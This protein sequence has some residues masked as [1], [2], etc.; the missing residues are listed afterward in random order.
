MVLTAQHKHTRHPLHTTRKPFLQADSSPNFNPNIWKL[1]I[2]KPSPLATFISC[3]S[4]WRGTHAHAR[5]RELEMKT[6]SV[7]AA[8]DKHAGCQVNYVRPTGLW[9]TRLVL[10]WLFNT[11]TQTNRG[12]LFV[13]AC[14]QKPVVELR[15]TSGTLE[16]RN[17]AKRCEVHICL[18]TVPDRGRLPDLLSLLE[19]RNHNPTFHA[20]VKRCSWLLWSGNVCV[21]VFNA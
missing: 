18:L 3:T 16:N 9:R 19:L 2:Q 8:A 11:W 15:R 4:R 5:A 7:P 6:A 17:G 10:Y 20:A 1:L 12:R 14:I 21:Y 13:P